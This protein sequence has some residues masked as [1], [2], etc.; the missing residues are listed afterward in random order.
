MKCNNDERIDLLENLFCQQGNDNNQGKAEANSTDSPLKE[1]GQ[2]SLKLKLNESYLFVIIPSIFV[3]LI[4]ILFNMYLDYQITEQAPAFV[5]FDKVKVPKADYHSFKSMTLKN[6]LEVLMISDPLSKF[7]SASLSVAAGSM[8]D[9]IFLPGLAHFCEHMLFLGSGKYPSTLEYFKIITENNGHFNAYTD[10]NITNFFFDI[11]N[12][13]FQDALSRFSRFFIDPLLSKEYLEKEV[14]SVHSEFE[15]NLIMDRRKRSQIFS[16][17]TNPGMNYDRFSTG[18]RDTLLHFNHSNID[19]SQFKDKMINGKID[20]YREMRNYH[21]KH[22][23]SEKMKLVI[24]SGLGIDSIQRLVEFKFNEVKPS[25]NFVL[26]VPANFTSSDSKLNDN[27]LLDP[28]KNQ[29]LASQVLKPLAQGSIVL[30][31]PI[32]SDNELNIKFIIPN[33]DLSEL[34]MW[35]PSQ[36]FSFLLENRSQGSLLS[37][38]KNLKLANQLSTEQDTSQIFWNTFNL[39]IG[40]TKEGTK[41]VKLVLYILNEYI[42]YMKENLISKDIYNLL[43][44]SSEINFNSP[45][46]HKQNLMAITSSLAAQLQKGNSY[47]AL[48]SNHFI[49][50]FDASILQNF[51]SNF[52]LE[53]AVIFLPLEKEKGS[54]QKGKLKGLDHLSKDEAL[55]LLNLT[56]SEGK[57]QYSAFESW[58]KTHFSLIKL[59]LTKIKEELDQMKASASKP[60]SINAES[61]VAKNLT[62]NAD[63]QEDKNRNGYTTE[64]PKDNSTNVKEANLTDQASSL[65]IANKTSITLSKKNVNSYDMLNQISFTKPNLTN[66][67]NYSNQ[68]E[69]VRN[70]DCKI[71]NATL[72][73]SNEGIP[74]CL[75]SLIST[76]EE[77]SDPNLLIKTT[78]YELWFKAASTYDFGKTVVSTLF[79]YSEEMSKS[80]T[81]DF[82]IKME[83]LTNIIKKKLKNLNYELG[84]FQDSVKVSFNRHGLKVMMNVH[85]L[86]AKEVYQSVIDLINVNLNFK[87]YTFFEGIKE[88]LKLKYSKEMKSQPNALAYT[89]LKKTIAEMTFLPEEYVA[90]IKLVTEQGFVDFANKFAQTTRG[91]KML[92]S[93]E[94]KESEAKDLLSI[95]LKAFPQMEDKQDSANEVPSNSTSETSKKAELNESMKEK[96]LIHKRYLG[97]NVNNAAVKCMFAGPATHSN[98]FY[99]NLVNMIIGNISFQELRIKKQMGYIA[100]NKIE[101]YDQ[102]LFFCIHVQGS[103]HSPLVMDNSIE[104]LKWKILNKLLSLTTADFNLAKEM[105]FDTFQERKLKLSLESEDLFSEIVNQS[106]SFNYLSTFKT[107]K[108]DL[109]QEELIKFWK[110]ISGLGSSDESFLKPANS[111]STTLN[112]TSVFVSNNLFKAR[113]TESK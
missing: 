46:Y 90:S 99:L 113:F 107:I 18:N 91:V 1:K 32:V 56:E 27:I 100:K 74:N 57:Y 2:N 87:N 55:K 36:Y 3:S 47:H 105:I 85:A 112:Q 34:F 33:I 50:D 67:E 9:P 11:H 62:V 66:I 15:R 26:S 60:N 17:L 80:M 19:Y 25:I 68:L 12:L 95:L 61:A 31:T 76:I 79:R 28:L 84:L 59:E 71:S 111:S 42:S 92:A 5:T 78:K 39:R 106:Y 109:R 63:D 21:S 89:Y 73:F 97:S 14:N 52:N 104:Q 48:N 40:L 23:T 58:Q 82:T 72:K 69:N 98:K 30:Y 51:V 81:V 38:L 37:V 4:V 93:G 54:K 64:A 83:I 103:T 43:K 77:D 6:G 10:K 20:L 96:G 7:S 13:A 110:K 53:K 44:A 88:E 102:K 24:I 65:E 22:Y 75:Q 16:S 86:L 108:A 41:K 49:K 29:S 45:Q 101:E 8:E 70:F 35:S 94:L